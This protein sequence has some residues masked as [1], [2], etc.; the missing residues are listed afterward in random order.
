MKKKL[1]LTIVSALLSALIF[2][3]CSAVPSSPE[4]SFAL[5]GS[6]LLKIH[7]A[8]AINS[9]DPTEA[10]NAGEI[11]LARLAFEGLVRESHGQIVAGLAEEWEISPD[12]K[13]YTFWLRPDVFFHNGNKFT[14]AD[15]KYSW[16]RAARRPACAY[17]FAN[18]QG[19]QAL[20]SGLERDITGLIA[21]DEQTLIV[22][23]SQPQDNFLDFLT[24]PP[25]FILNRLELIE[26]GGSFAL[27]G[28]YFTARPPPS[29]T[30]LFAFSEWLGSGLVSLGSNPQYWNGIAQLDRLEFS[31][32]GLTS[33]AMVAFFSGKMDI[34]EN[35]FPWDFPL[36]L[37]DNEAT[38]LTAPVR[39]FHYL[40]INPNI[41]PFDNLYLRQAL[42]EAVSP[43]SVLT[44]ARGNYG[45]YPYDGLSAY[46]NSLD[47]IISA[48]KTARPV[49]DL[50]RAANLE[51]AWPQL[52]LYCA[53]DPEDQKAAGNILA[54]W[55]KL[56]FS[57]ELRVLAPKDFHR[58]A[59]EG[60]LGLYL[61]QF[62]D[63]GGGLEVFFR[64]VTENLTSAAHL[65]PDTLE[66]A[67]QAQAE[68]KQ[69]LLAQAE[70]ELSAEGIIQILYFKRCATAVTNEWQELKLD[71]GGIYQLE[72]LESNRRA[73]S[74]PGSRE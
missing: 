35:A 28:D 13:T 42:Q 25:A 7:L 29:G 11:L 20:I 22:H 59:R 67:Y 65:W 69:N 23:L 31:Y 30:G 50:L 14:A 32:G 44:A 71:Q 62:V 70:K 46:W 38:M 57:P 6:R 1:H 63:K 47:D 8:Q 15:C 10:H 24:T 5:T 17:L 61:G 37:G 54:S 74:P 58:R 36:V 19:A 51:G 18:I 27:P 66:K 16:E 3:G 21:E 56:G 72:Q 34:V 33:D 45:V 52:V 60:E 48:E 26:R 68:H 49:A 41:P 73:A 9:I 43:S 4:V 64:E 39:D 55:E 53:Q 2:S 40:A 12:G